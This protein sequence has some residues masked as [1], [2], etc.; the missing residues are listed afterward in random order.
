M[1]EGSHVADEVGY[2]TLSMETCEVIRLRLG[3]VL[4]TDEPFED[5]VRV[6]LV[7]PPVPAPREASNDAPH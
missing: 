3:E 6:C 5:Y 2:R 4:Q 1:V 7:W